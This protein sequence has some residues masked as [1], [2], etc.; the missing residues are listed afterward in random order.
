MGVHV[1]PGDA[2]FAGTG[3]LWGV[4]LVQGSGSAAPSDPAAKPST[5]RETLDRMTI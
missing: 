5:C 4:A 3:G 1:A 2:Y